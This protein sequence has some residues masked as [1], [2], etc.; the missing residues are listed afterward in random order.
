MSPLS[1]IQQY[2][3]NGMDMR[4]AMTG[5]Q[6]FDVHDT[7]MQKLNLKADFASQELLSCRWAPDESAHQPN[8][9]DYYTAPSRPKRSWCFY[10]NKIYTFA[11]RRQAWSQNDWAGPDVHPGAIRHRERGRPHRLANPRLSA[12][13]EE[14]ERRGCG[15][16]GATIHTI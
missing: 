13:R 2:K 9:S 4:H 12:A 15:R 3:D 11:S 6:N 10:R 16:L 1:H 7:N 5:E 8:S 14:E